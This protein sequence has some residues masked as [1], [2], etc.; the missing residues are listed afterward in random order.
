V[1][2]S[3]VGSIAITRVGIPNAVHLDAALD[4]AVSTSVLPAAIIML[5][6]N[7]CPLGR[8]GCPFLSVNPTL[9]SSA[10]RLHRKHRSKR[11]LLKEEDTSKPGYTPS[12]K[13]IHKSQ[14]KMARH[15]SP[16]ALNRVVLDDIF[17]W[18][19]ETP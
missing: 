10:R 6:F 9:S 4:A 17:K 1:K 15:C 18:K 19:P 13:K 5:I 12:C 14:M 16:S 7:G 11:D 3:A 8:Y 2:C